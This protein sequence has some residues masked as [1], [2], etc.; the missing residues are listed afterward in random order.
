MQIPDSGQKKRPKYFQQSV[1]DA[2]VIQAENN[3]ISL[4]EFS[5]NK[6]YIHDFSCLHSMMKVSFLFA[7]SCMCKM[8]LL[9]KQ[10]HFRNNR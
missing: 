1:Q 10:E 6:V 5:N 7:L 2:I 3:N 8:Y 9:T 4:T